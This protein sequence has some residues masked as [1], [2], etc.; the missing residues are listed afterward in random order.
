M[1]K[2]RV[3]SI[4][5]KKL[6]HFIMDNNNMKRNKVHKVLMNHSELHD[7]YSRMVESKLENNE[8]VVIKNKPTLNKKLSITH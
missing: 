1:E 3:L 7:F 5:D 6:C 8:T 2:T 4:L